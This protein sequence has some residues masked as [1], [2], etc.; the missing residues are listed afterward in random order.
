MSTGLFSKAG[1]ISPSERA[2]ASVLPPH[3]ETAAQPEAG[4]GR[5]DQAAC[6]EHL[7]EP[8]T[9]RLVVHEAVPR[10]VGDLPPLGRQG[11]EGGQTEGNGLSALLIAQNQDGSLLPRPRPHR[12]EGGEGKC[13]EERAAGQRNQ[14]SRRLRAAT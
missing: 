14:R 3:E 4:T 7:S 9:L 11:A 5:I 2:N 12:C 13:R 8:R 1:A 6:E 10:L